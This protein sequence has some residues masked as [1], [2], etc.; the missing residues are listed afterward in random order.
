M[1]IAI[2]LPA[3]NCQQTIE[4]AVNSVINQTFDDWHLYIVNDYSLDNTRK[5]LSKFELDDRIT[6]IDNS[7]NLGAAE[8]RNIAIRT[9]IEEYISFIDSDDEWLECKLEFQHEV[10]NKGADVCITDYYYVSPHKKYF[11]KSRYTL[12]DIDV[13]LKKKVRVC[14]SSLIYRRA[15][16][17]NRMKEFEKIGHEDF[18]YI[19]E[20]LRLY[21]NIYLIKKPLVNYYVTAGSLSDNKIKASKWHYN[22]LKRMFNS[23][24]KVLYYYAHYAYN[25]LLFKYKVR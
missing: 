18:L 22:L 2:I 20:L 5:I 14:F 11:V 12:I 21:K 19:Y 17:C 7:S 9:S 25:A 15:P 3:Y 10:L 1:K 6:I 8:S 24:A 23:K 4:R 13:F 16:S